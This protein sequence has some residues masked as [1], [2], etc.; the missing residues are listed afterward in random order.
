MEVI[1][2]TVI[3]ITLK[4]ILSH[5]TLGARINRLRNNCQHGRTPLRG[6]IPGAAIGGKCPNL[7]F[8]RITA[9]VIIIVETV[10]TDQVTSLWHCVLQRQPG[11]LYLDTPAGVGVYLSVFHTFDL[12]VDSLYVFRCPSKR[13]LAVV[14]GQRGA[15]LGVTTVEVELHTVVLPGRGRIIHQAVVADVHD[16]IKILRI[17]QRLPATGGIGWFNHRDDILR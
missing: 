4:G 1:A 13:I 7:I 17:I 12:G 14:S 11:E 8:T 5:E 9:V 3:H 6:I 15:I 10:N 2:G 16:H